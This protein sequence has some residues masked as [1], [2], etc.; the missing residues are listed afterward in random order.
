MCNLS[1]HQ[2]DECNFSI[3]VLFLLWNQETLYKKRV[4]EKRATK[5]E[6]RAHPKEGLKVDFIIHILIWLFQYSLN[7]ILGKKLRKSLQFLENGR[8]ISHNNTARLSSFRYILQTTQNKHIP[9]LFKL[10]EILINDQ[11]I[12]MVKLKLKSQKKKKPYF[13]FE[14]S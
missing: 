9:S 12:K 14:S 3:I 13:W 8:Q 11:E 2:G 1:I 4:N 7:L 6:K 5:N 10:I